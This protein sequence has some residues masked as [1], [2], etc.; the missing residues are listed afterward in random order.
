MGAIF[1]TPEFFDNVNVTD[2]WGAPS[3]PLGVFGV[4]DPLDLAEG[5]GQYTFRSETLF[6]TYGGALFPEFLQ[7]WYFRVHFFPATL[8]FGSFA[9]ATVKTVFMWNSFLTEINL[10]TVIAGAG[11]QGVTFTAPTLPAN[12]DPLQQLSASFTA[13]RDGPTLIVETFTFTFDNGF[14]GVL[15]VTGTRVTA[16][17]LEAFTLLPNWQNGVTITETWLTEV[18][19]SRSGREQR[20]ALRAAPRKT[21]EFTIHLTPSTLA[22]Y[23]QQLS[24]TKQSRFVVPELPHKTNVTVVTD[25]MTVTVDSV[26]Y[27]IAADAWVV[28][29]YG[30]QTSARQVKTVTLGV[31]VFWLDDGLT[32]AA[33]AVLH[34]GLICERPDELDGTRL[35]NM[36]GTR[37]IQLAVYP[38]TEVLEDYG[39]AEITFDSREVLLLAPNWADGQNETS[40]RPS[41]LVDPGGGVWSRFFPDSDLSEI[42]EFAFLGGSADAVDN[43]RKFF[44]RQKGRQ[45]EFYVSTAEYDLDIAEPL[46]SATAIFRTA[47]VDDALAYAANTTRRAVEIVLTDGTVMRKLVSTI[48]AVSDSDGDWSEFAVVGAWAS[49]IPVEDIERVSWL[50]LCRNSSDI[51][52]VE[53]LTNEVGRTKMQIQSLEYLAAE[54]LI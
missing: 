33:G 45:R 2:S 32:W 11:D 21:L 26:P 43:T 39:V 47:G 46:A 49:T 5:S 8:Q 54:S 24:R 6:T 3:V 38:G 29:R 27:W 28:M 20:A 1:A 31:V 14:V 13:T 36:S 22:A 19:A 53:W 50:L 10:T 25:A 15:G 51:L 44:H 41:E 7:D 4:F 12:F 52:E 16:A 18:N 37:S 48:T 35:T 42:V 30:S 34:P 17:A 9:D 40:V 23:R